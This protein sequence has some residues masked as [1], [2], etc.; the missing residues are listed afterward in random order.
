MKIKLPCSLLLTDCPW[1]H[2]KPL[3]NFLTPR[4]FPPEL[5]DVLLGTS[6]E[7]LAASVIM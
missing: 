2:V 5:K 3:I 7:H 6:A 4:L 1:C